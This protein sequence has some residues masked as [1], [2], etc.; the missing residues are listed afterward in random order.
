MK[1]ISYRSPSGKDRVALWAADQAWDAGSWNPQ[2]GPDMKAFLEQ[3]EAAM[4]A[5]RELE[6]RVLQGDAPIKPLALE[7]KDWL[8][9]V[10]ASLLPRWLCLQATCR[11]SSSEPG[12]RYDP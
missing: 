4:D 1:L 5:M 8:A 6:Q 11:L 2:C 12:G 7:A 10:Q 9:P 3:G